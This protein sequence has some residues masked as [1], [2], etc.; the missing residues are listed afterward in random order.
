LSILNKFEGQKC[1]GEC[2]VTETCP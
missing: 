1:K 2:D